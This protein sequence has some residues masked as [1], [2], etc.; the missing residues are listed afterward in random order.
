MKGRT[1]K[2]IILKPIRKGKTN[3]TLP[4]I[5]REKKLVRFEKQLNDTMN[6]FRGVK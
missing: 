2:A 5:K 1:S 3:F 4:H 6:Y